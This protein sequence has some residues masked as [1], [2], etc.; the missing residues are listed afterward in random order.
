M[1]NFLK[2][3]LFGVYAMA[4]LLLPIC[5]FLASSRGYFDIFISLVLFILS[6][7]LITGAA[8]LVFDL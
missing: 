3:L 7:A 8:Y 1:K 5:V 6:L 2:G 4:V